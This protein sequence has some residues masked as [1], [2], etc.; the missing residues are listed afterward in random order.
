[1]MTDNTELS[2]AHLALILDALGAM[3]AG[4][5]HY[6]VLLIESLGRTRALAYALAVLGHVVELAA[7]AN[8]LGRDAALA[9]I[10]QAVE[11]S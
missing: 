2:G 10:R 9:M 6:A 3:W 1:M 11:L 8:H 4:E 5:D 7:E